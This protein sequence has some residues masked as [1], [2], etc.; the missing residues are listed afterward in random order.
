M[1]TVTRI[2]LTPVMVKE[3]T[4]IPATHPTLLTRLLTMVDTADKAETPTQVLLQAVTHTR[5]RLELPTTP[6]MVATLASADTAT[7]LRLASVALQASMPA[8][9]AQTPTVA[10]IHR[11]TVSPEFKV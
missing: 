3:A 1:V 6:L 7:M 11:E 4:A 9:T 8:D 10:S 5:A 2:I